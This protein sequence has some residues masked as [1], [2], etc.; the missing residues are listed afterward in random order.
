MKIY[1][2]K[3]TPHL[4]YLTSQQ[5]RSTCGKVVYCNVGEED[6]WIHRIIVD[7][8][9]KVWARWVLVG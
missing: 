4:D 5:G 8:K 6:G 1:P 2:V 3:K 7:E 9:R